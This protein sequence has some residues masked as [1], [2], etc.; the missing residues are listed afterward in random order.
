MEKI[1]SFSELNSIIVMLGEQDLMVDTRHTQDRKLYDMINK[2]NRLK[3]EVS[4]DDIIR[5][6]GLYKIDSFEDI[7][8]KLREYFD[9]FDIEFKIKQEIKNLSL[10]YD[11]FNTKDMK[12]EKM[13]GGKEPGQFE[14]ENIN[15][16]LYQVRENLNWI[17]SSVIKEGR[18]IKFH[19]NPKSIRAIKFLLAFYSIDEAEVIHEALY[20]NLNISIPGIKVK[21]FANGYCS[22][23]MDSS[24][25]EEM[26]KKIAK[27]L[28]DVINGTFAFYVNKK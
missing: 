19:S 16:L 24:E 5:S 18:E 15:P 7:T 26:K 13:Y 21:N 12:L 23:F 22:I 3:I 10:Q 14:E 2:E 28:H 4:H 27:T 6:L 17:R 25:F 20:K 8:L 11:S 1:K 9:Q